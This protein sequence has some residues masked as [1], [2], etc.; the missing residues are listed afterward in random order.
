MATTVNRY[1]QTQEN[2]YQ[3]RSLQELMLAPAYKRGKHDELDASIAQYETQLAKADALDIHGGKLK[4]EQQKL[5]DSMLSQRDKLESEGFSQSAKSDF[6]RFNKDYQQAIGPQGNIGKI[7]KARVSYETEKENLLKNAT[8][9]GYGPKEI[10]DKLKVAYDKYKADF[11][12]TGNITAFEAPLPPAYQD[13]QKDILE[14]GK[15]MGS[16]TL[17]KLKQDGYQIGIDKGMYVIKTQEGE[18]IETSNDKNIQTAI[19]YLNSKWVDKGGQG[20]QSADW[21]GLTPDVIQDQ[22]NNGLGLQ[23]EFKSIDNT[24]TKYQFQSIPQAKTDENGENLN[25]IR[26]KIPG[27]NITSVDPNSPLLALD[28]VENLQFNEQ[29]NIKDIS[30]NDLTYEEYIKGMEQNLPTGSFISFNNETGLYELNSL[31]SKHSTQ[32]STTPIYKQGHQIKEEITGL[33]SQN[34]LLDNLSDKELIERMQSFK[35]NLSSNYINDVQLPGS[36]FEWY[37]DDL[38]GNLAGSGE[39]SAG[40]IIDKSITIDGKQLTFD[41]VIDDLGYDSVEEFKTKGLPVINSYVP[42][43]GK[44]KGTVYNNKGEPENIFVEAPQQVTNSTAIT[45]AVTSALMAGKGFTKLD[46]PSTPQGYAYYMI[47]DFQNDPKIVLTDN[48]YANNAGELIQVTPTLSGDRINLVN[49]ETSAILEFNDVYREEERSLKTNPVYLGLTG[50][51]K[52]SK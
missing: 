44:F 8:A 6:I 40:T 49:T 13:L 7:D 2:R 41:E 3:P 5:Y 12:E 37:S 47:N 30:G 39:K 4:E 45:T 17:T 36:S 50:L 51:D 24:Q 52:T 34:P 28:K 31:A 9:M 43:L 26:N 25:F 48:L 33:R 21:Q 14:I 23:R 35:A 18:V 1:T 20:T 29:G 10:Q 15:S 32:Y 19:N 22:I 42:S 38:F 11:E 46:I 16:E 27:F